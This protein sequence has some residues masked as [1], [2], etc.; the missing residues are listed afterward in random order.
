MDV[1][2]NGYPAFWGVVKKGFGEKKINKDLKCPMNYLADLKVKEFHP[3]TPTLP[4]EDFF[5]KFENTNNMKKNY[6][7]E[8]MIE[9]YSL[10][11]FNSV[12]SDTDRDYGNDDYFLLR[13]DFDSLIQDIRST[14]LSRNY[15]GLMSWLIDRAFVLTTYTK[16]NA[17][18]IKA[19]TAQNKALLLKVLYEVSPRNLLLCFSKNLKI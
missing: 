3:D 2:N 15:L 9:K 7:V 8:R 14:S 13:D 16:R 19:K 10:H 6:R 18:Q 17:F 1:Q 12:T 5:I 11:M 4:M